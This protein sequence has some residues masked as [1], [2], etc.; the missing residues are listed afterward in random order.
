MRLQRFIEASW[1]T[2]IYLFIYFYNWRTLVKWRH[3]LFSRTQTVFELLK[4]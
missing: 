4:I 1:G 3:Q 2:L